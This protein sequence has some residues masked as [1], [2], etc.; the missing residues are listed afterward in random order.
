MNGIIKAGTLLG[1][2]SAMIWTEASASEVTSIENTASI[3]LPVGSNTTN[4]TKWS[5]FNSWQN[6][7]KPGKLDDV[8]IPDNSSVLL[9]EGVDNQ[10]NL[11]RE[12]SGIYMPRIKNQSIRIILMKHCTGGFGTNQPYGW[13]IGNFLR[14]VPG[15]FFSMWKPMNTKTRTL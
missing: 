15:S 10:L 13:G 12:P 6:S 1:L 11:S 7:I 14:Q 2:V 4:L 5:D 8:I 9:D 3:S